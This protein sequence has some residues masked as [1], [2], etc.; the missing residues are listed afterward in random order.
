MIRKAKSEDAKSIHDAHMLSIQ[1]I[2]SK[3]HTPK[4][5]NAWGG[6]PFNED[7]RVSAIQNQNVWVVELDNRIEGYG[8]LRIYEKDGQR[9]AHVMGLYLTQKALGKKFGEQMFSQMLNE[10]KLQ[11]FR[12]GVVSMPFKTGKGTAGDRSHS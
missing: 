8:H 4:E 2:C 6:R 7:K 9:L 1:T 11:N 10:A 3:D 5:I 12:M